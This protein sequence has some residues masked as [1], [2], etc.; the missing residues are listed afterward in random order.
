[1]TVARIV[2]ADPGCRICR[3]IEPGLV[4]T[5]GPLPE[6]YRNPAFGGERSE[7]GPHGHHWY[8]GTSFEPDEEDKPGGTLETPEDHTGEYGARAVHHWN[9][10]LGVHFSS[11]HHV[12]HD[13][14]ADTKGGP[15]T[16]SRVAHASLHM[17]NPAHYEDEDDMAHHAASW[18]HE[19]GHRYL[20]ENAQAHKAF[21]HANFEHVTDHDETEGKGRSYD[22]QNH[23]V[24]EPSYRE[25]ISSI[26]RH[27]P[28]NHSG[29]AK[30]KWLGTHPDR[31]QIT[32]GFRQ[33]LQ[34]KGHDGIVY[35]NSYEGPYKHKCAIAFPQTPVGIHH[36]QWLHPNHQERE[37]PHED[38]DQMK[39]F[40]RRMTIVAADG[41]PQLD[42]D[43]TEEDTGGA[44]R[45]TKI[46]L[47]G[48][49]PETGDEVGTLKY[50][51]PRRKADKIYIDGLD[52][53]EQHRGNGYAGQLMDELQRRHPKTPIDHGDRTDDGK[54]WWAGYSKG[55][56][57]QKGRTAS[58]EPW[59]F[60]HYNLEG[61]S[62]RVFGQE[63]GG[64]PREHRLDY[65]ITPQNTIKFHNVDELPEHA[66]QPMKGG[67]FERHQLP[68]YQPK[69]EDARPEEPAKG[70]WY[71]G[72]TVA[73]VTH[74]L[75]AAQHGGDVT[76]PSDTDRNYAYATHNHDDAWNYAEKAWGADDHGRRPRVYE[77]KPI[78]GMKHVERDP[79]HDAQGQS[80][81][82]FSGDHRSKKGWKVV[83]E[84][85]MPERM[86]DPEDWDR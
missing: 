67:V 39:L 80:R 57:V 28:A 56:S 1:M 46:T 5:A 86:G 47:R 78:G 79:Q 40:G 73:G 16:H 36:W 58:L 71:H 31:E 4:A 6:P 72:T 66:R 17:R 23:L 26:D 61:R 49:H 48:L 42:F 8:H 27:G 29:Q 81:S 45:P 51:V 14:F 9:T 25:A 43:H 12:A 24:L 33:H 3:S 15:G 64:Q 34:L 84:V 11:L 37:Q 44:K 41:P 32:Q 30:E 7:G 55:K 85:P 75:P 83:R 38:P 35:G 21:V 59:Q 65:S 2:H 63:P 18:A 54:K 50:L 77:V 60:E 76:F 62:H 70:P 13:E 69:H 68:E 53:H 82:N 20:P 74:V 19:Q 52:V 22:Y 10:D